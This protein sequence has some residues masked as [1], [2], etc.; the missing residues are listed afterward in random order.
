MPERLVGSTI[1]TTAA[2]R[3]LARGITQH[4]ILD[5]NALGTLIGIQAASRALAAHSTTGQVIMADGGMVLV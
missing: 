1:V 4:A 2:A 5:V 3:G